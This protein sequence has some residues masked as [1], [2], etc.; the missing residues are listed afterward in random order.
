MP[1]PVIL[2]GAALQTA[3]RYAVTNGAKKAIKKYGPEVFKQIQ[4]DSGLKT[5][6]NKV[7]N[8]RMT[9]AQRKTMSKDFNKD[10]AKMQRESKEMTNKQFM[11]K[12]DKD[13]IKQTRIDNIKAEN[14]TAA[15]KPLYG[16]G[17]AMYNKGGQP[18]YK[19]GDM[20]KA[21]PC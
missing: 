8:K 21:K 13:M 4:K 6:G 12:V 16:G 9:A 11:A 5:V 3:G 14:M 19:S 17:R 15:R 20:P 7:I 1:I 2:V 10:L 18:E